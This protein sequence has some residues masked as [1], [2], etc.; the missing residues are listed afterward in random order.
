MTDVSNDF[1][2]EDE[3]VEKV[4]ADYAK[5]EHGTTC[6]PS[7]GQTRYLALAGLSAAPATLNWP[8]RE[9]VEH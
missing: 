4:R 8:A 5:G 3:P 2:E 1:F 6:R 7:S 9:L